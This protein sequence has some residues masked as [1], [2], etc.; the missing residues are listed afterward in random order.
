MSEPEM[1]ALTIEMA[2]FA[3]RGLGDVG[4]QLA[5][6]FGKHRSVASFGTN[7]RRIQ[8]L[9]DGHD[10]TLEVTN[11]ELNSARHLSLRCRNA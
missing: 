8:P 3:V 6:E 11:D 5:V 2:K 1:N 7:I 10:S 9:H 4:L